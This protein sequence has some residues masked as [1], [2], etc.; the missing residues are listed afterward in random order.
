MKKPVLLMIL[1]GYGLAKPSAGNAI[2]LANTPNMDKYLKEYPNRTLEA[3]GLAVGLPKGQM[4]NSEVGHLNLGAGR[5]VYQSLTRITKA[6]SDGSFFK[7]AAFLEAIK[8][9]KKYNSALHIYGLLSDGGVHSH[10]KHFEAMLKMAKDYDVKVYL[11]CFM[12]GRDTPPKS[13]INYIKAIEKYMQSINCGEIATISGR[14]YAMDRD[15]NYDRTA[16]AYDC[17]VNGIGNT[18]SSAV[19]CLEN[20][21]KNDVTDEFVVPTVINKAGLIKDNDSIIF[22]NFRPDRA[23]QISTMMTNM[24][25]EVVTVKRNKLNNLCYVS[26]MLYANSVKGLIA[27]KIIDIVNGYGDVISKNGL[28]QLRIAETE[29]YA[30]V[31]FFF[32]G[33]VNREIK[34]STRVLVGSPKVATYDLQPEMSANIVT[35]KLLIEL[36]K[37]IYDTV[38][39]NYAN[40]DMVG[41]TGNIPATV[42]AVETVDKCMAKV[43][44]KVNSMGGVCLICA[45][46]GN[47]DKML[48]EDGSPYTAHTTALVPFIITS[49]D[50]T[51]DDRAEG[52]LGDI[53]PTML[54]ILKIEQPQEMTGK[55]LI[56]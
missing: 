18:A 23:I 13:G 24:D 14:Y 4:G 35:D 12:D 6:I 46:H 32:D 10:I 33:G 17:M 25:D 28:K 20:S 50:F 37:G 22:M 30:H 11:H 21:Y 15:K 5:T 38:I 39:L 26:M 51:L 36:D 47:A 56:K 34:G 45:D 41:H 52:T 2:S 8:H 42:K 40:C 54:Q 44:D 49:N 27:F 1:D 43:V 48:S 3:S 31:T 19:E 29:K 16:K 7:N 9:T 53:A 55:S